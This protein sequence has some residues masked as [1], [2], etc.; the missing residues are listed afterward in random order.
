MVLLAILCVYLLI[1]IIDNLCFQGTATN[2]FADFAPSILAICA[3]YTLVSWKKAFSLDI[4]TKR[5]LLT[6]KY[7]LKLHQLAFCVYSVDQGLEI[8]HDESTESDRG[9]SVKRSSLNYVKEVKNL[10]LELEMII[11]EIATYIA[12]EKNNFNEM[13]E[14]ISSFSSLQFTCE[15]ILLN[16]EHLL[17][18]DDGNK[19]NGVY[20]FL[21]KYCNVKKA[22]IEEAFHN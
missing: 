13:S 9:F 4:E 6:L 3:I 2:V 1:L 16:P 19:F 18:F 10:V 11:P 20:E 5:K 15:N 17:G 14:A 22:E 12:Q 8:K 21:V 7:Q